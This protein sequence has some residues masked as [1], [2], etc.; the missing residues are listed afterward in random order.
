[1]ANA[2]PEPQIGEVYDTKDRGGGNY[3]DANH[4]GVLTHDE[5]VAG[6]HN[7][8]GDDEFEDYFDQEK[9]KEQQGGLEAAK[10]AIKF[11]DQAIFTW[12]KRR[13]ASGDRIQ[14]SKDEIAYIDREIAFLGGKRDNVSQVQAERRAAHKKISEEV[15]VCEEGLQ[16]MIDNAKNLD[17]IAA[18]GAKGIMARRHVSAGN[19][20]ISNRESA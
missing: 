16:Q 5:A 15:R 10:M 20:S 11:L 9:A 7:P 19:L 2:Q 18:K 1:M 12:R 4:D 13:K 17:R 8:V 14:S 6:D 3:K